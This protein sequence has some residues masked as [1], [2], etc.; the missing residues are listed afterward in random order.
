MYRTLYTMY[1]YTEHCTQIVTTLLIFHKGE[2]LLAHEPKSEKLGFA[3]TVVHVHIYTCIYTLHWNLQ[4]KTHLTVNT[5]VY[6]I[7]ASVNAQMIST[8]KCH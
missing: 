3:F 5:Y 1:I 6:T 4:C 7:N 8:Q 2:T